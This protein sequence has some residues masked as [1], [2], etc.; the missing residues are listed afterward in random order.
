MSTEPADKDDL[1]PTEAPQRGTALAA[2]LA[3]IA[4]LSKV[5]RPRSRVLYRGS[6]PPRASAGACNMES[7]Q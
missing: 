3:A 1:V 7:D 5:R 4:R 2:A 6:A